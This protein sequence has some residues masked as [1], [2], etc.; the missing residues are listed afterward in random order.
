MYYSLMLYRYTQN[1]AEVELKPV[2]DKLS[3]NDAAKISA[4]AKQAVETMQR[5][6]I[7]D[8]MPDGSGVKFAPK[9]SATRAQAAAMITRFYQA[10]KEQG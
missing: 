10:L 3:F 1:I 9:E 6:G 2:K 5:S 4:E 8:G 7:I